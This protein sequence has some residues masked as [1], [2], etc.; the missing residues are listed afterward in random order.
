VD[1]FSDWFRLD[2]DGRIEAYK[3][4]SCDDWHEGVPLC[5][6]AEAPAQVG[7]VPDDEWPQRVTLGSDQCIL[8]L[9]D[10]THYFMRGLLRI[11][12]RGREDFVEHG[13]WVSLSEA[14]YERAGEL[15]ETVGRESEPPYFGWLCTEVPGYTDTMLLKTRVFTQPVGARPLLEVFEPEQ[16]PLVVDARTGIDEARLPRLVFAGLGLAEDGAADGA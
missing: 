5:F 6:H 3:C 4:G 2:A 9:D 7:L 8:E 1:D 11:P 10:G 15:W 13:V 12:I 16:H 14:S